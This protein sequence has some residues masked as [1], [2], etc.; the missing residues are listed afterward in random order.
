MVYIGP[1]GV[2]RSKNGLPAA[3]PGTISPAATRDDISRG[4]SANRSLISTPPSRF[5][6]WLTRATGARPRMIAATL[7]AGSAEGRG[8]V[9]MSRASVPVVAKA[10]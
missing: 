6:P 7:A 1:S 8:R 10:T 9:A 4:G 5:C 2:S 3:S